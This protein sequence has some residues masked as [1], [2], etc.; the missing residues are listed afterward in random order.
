MNSERALNGNDDSVV[1]GAGLV[2]VDVVRLGAGHV[3]C[4]VGWV[5]V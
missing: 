3:G 4:A 2:L 5:R 1:A